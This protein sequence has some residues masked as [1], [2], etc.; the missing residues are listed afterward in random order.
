[1]IWPCIIIRGDAECGIYFARAHS[2]KRVIRY[3][4]MNIIIMYLVEHNTI[5]IPSE[6]WIFFVLTDG[7]F[8]ND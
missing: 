1:M 4:I 5:I 3:T 8:R 2:R 7:T 6:Y